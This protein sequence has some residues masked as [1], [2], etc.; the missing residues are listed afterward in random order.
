MAAKHAAW[1]MDTPICQHGCCFRCI[2]MPKRD[3]GD[4]SKCH[5]A[6]R[7]NLAY[8]YVANHRDPRPLFAAAYEARAQKAEAAGHKAEASAHRAAAAR[9]LARAPFVCP[10]CGVSVDA[11][12]EKR[13]ADEMHNATEAG[14]TQ[15]RRMHSKS[16]SGACGGW[17]RSCPSTTAPAPPAHCTAA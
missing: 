4:V 1:A 12:L 10:H 13:E 2:N 5:A 16:H 9:W 11:A 17:H 6:P 15:I 8:Q 7:R 14:Q 3:W